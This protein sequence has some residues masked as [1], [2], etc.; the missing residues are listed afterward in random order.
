[1]KLLQKLQRVFGRVPVVADAIG[2]KLPRA[3]EDLLFSIWVCYGTHRHA[4]RQSLRKPGIGQLIKIIN[5]DPQLKLLYKV[6]F[7]GCI[8]E[9]GPSEKCV[10]GGF[11]TTLCFDPK[12]G[13]YVYGWSDYPFAETA[14]KRKCTR[15]TPAQAKK[16]GVTYE[17]LCQAILNYTQVRNYIEYTR[18][19]NKDF[20]FDLSPFNQPQE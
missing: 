1:M 8:L 7:I 17:S 20:E 14:P 16:Y 3:V 10:G 11:G 12:D 13:L 5:S 2:P 15:F 19:F 6:S 18:I 4:Y 9:L